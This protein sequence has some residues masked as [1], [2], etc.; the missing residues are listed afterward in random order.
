MQINL[1]ES[2]TH[3]V[4]KG[5]CTSESNARAITEQIGFI[6]VAINAHCFTSEFMAAPPYLVEEYAR[7]K[8]GTQYELSGGRRWY[9]WS[10]G[11]E[12]DLTT[13]R[14]DVADADDEFCIYFFYSI[15]VVDAHY[16]L[17]LNMQMDAYLYNC[18]EYSSFRHEGL[19]QII[20]K[21]V[22]EAVETVQE[23]QRQLVDTARNIF[24]YSLAW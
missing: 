23:T 15:D 21:P 5:D 8:V 10:V 4:T 18:H 14:I 24:R 1:E 19:E 9:V 2:T 12:H 17:L 11:L 22:M 13:V 16:L 6:E 3:H 7:W 20:V